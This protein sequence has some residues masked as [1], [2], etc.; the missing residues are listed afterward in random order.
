RRTT[1]LRRNWTLADGDLRPLSIGG[2]PGRHFCEFDAHGHCAHL[3]C[4]AGATHSTTVEQIPLRHVASAGLL[5]NR[6]DRL[7]K[8]SAAALLDTLRFPPASRRSADGV[9]RR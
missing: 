9:W 7:T 3:N 8:E 6:P 1:Y 5:R 4:N 2:D